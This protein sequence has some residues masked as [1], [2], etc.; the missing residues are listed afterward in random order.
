MIK[1]IIVLWVI[2]SVII[3][4]IDDKEY[5]WD[6]LFKIFIGLTA[7]ALVL[8][9]TNFYDPSKTHSIATI[10]INGTITM[11]LLISF[12]E[13]ICVLGP[14]SLIHIIHE[15]ITYNKKED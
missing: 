11:T 9:G 13:A 7:L 6:G 2:A 12:V 4:Y 10:E 14:I 5:R 1:G 3:V 15:Y 8:N